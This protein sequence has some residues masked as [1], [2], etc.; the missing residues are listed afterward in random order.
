MSAGYAPPPATAVA[1]RPVATLRPFR[2]ASGVLR[3]DLRFAP[4]FA[5]KRSAS[6][7]RVSGAG[8]LAPAGSR[9]ERGD[10]LRL[11]F[12][13]PKYPGERRSIWSP[14]TSFRGA[15][16]RGDL[17]GNAECGWWWRSKIA[18]PGTALGSSRQGGISAPHCLRP[19]S[20]RSRDLRLAGSPLRSDCSP[21][22][23][24]GAGDLRLELGGV[25][26]PTPRHPRRARH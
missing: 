20:L 1:F 12:A 10:P 15:S 2:C 14:V 26:T 11:C 19:R 17:C 8:R 25:R 4:T 24:G 7:P 18:T 21:T 16:R 3:E 6:T 23:T 13:I 9:P 5:G 22:M